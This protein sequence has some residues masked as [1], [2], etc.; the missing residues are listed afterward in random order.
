ME[1]VAFEQKY[2]E[3][4]LAFS[5][6]MWPEKSEAYLKYRL[7]QIP[8]DP[9]DIRKNLLVL[10]DDGKIVG[11][12]LY[13]PTRARIN[14]REEKIYWGHDM[15]VEEKYRGEA[16]L[17]LIIEMDEN[18][19]AFG[20]GT[21]DINYKIQKE[22]GTKFIGA[23]RHYVIFNL[24]SFRLPLFRLKLLKLKKEMNYRFPEKISSGGYEF[25]KLTSVKGLTIPDNGYW[26]G[27]EFDIEF[28]RDR[29]FLN[30]RFFENFT[31][32]HFYKLEISGETDECYFV[33]RPS[34]EGGYPVLSVVDFRFN[35][36]KPVQFIR[37]LNA[38]SRIGRMN[39]IP[40]TTC[41]TSFNFKRF[42]F[43]PLIYGRSALEHIVTTYPTGE[44]P[45][46]IVT[47]ADADLDFLN[48]YN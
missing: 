23:A 34:V 42:N 37:L 7:Y 46:L 35:P 10:N 19:T 14:G 15:I 48:L 25:R 2:Y 33:V 44:N 27:T 13:F 12:T 5:K 43:C 20:F 16:G 17:L 39:R 3:E 47:N 24:W 36:G 32:Y 45:G 1:V 18:K 30:N 4:L 21:T 31:K 28:V 29:H 11:C 26:T 41:R 38:A 22:L 40:L 8:E 9:E 6:K